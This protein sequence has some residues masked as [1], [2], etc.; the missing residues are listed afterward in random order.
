[1]DTPSS[2]DEQLRQLTERLEKLERLVQS[3]IQRIFAIEKRLASEAPPVQTTSTYSSAEVLRGPARAPSAQAHPGAEF[4]VAPPASPPKQPDLAQ[5]RSDILP[6]AVPPQSTTPTG[7][8]LESLIGGNWLNKI[9]VVAI[10]LGMAY[11]LKYAIDNQWIGEMGRV[12]LGVI[13]GLGFLLWGEALQKRLYRGYGL[14]ISAGGITILYF[15]IFAAFNFYS[16]I[17]QLPALFLM[18]LITTTAVL[19]ALRHDAK[20]IALIGILGGFLTPVM[21]STG[22][23]NQSGLFSYVAL[24]DLGILALAYFK[25]WRELNLLA[26][27]FTQ[28]TF[29]GWSLSFYTSAKLW[30]TELFLTLFFLIFAVMSFLYNIVYQRKT[31]FRDLS[32]ILLN[33]AAYFLWTYGL[34]QEKYFDYLG[35]YAILMAVVYVGL[36]SFAYQRARQ[37]AYLVLVFLGMGLTSLT[38]AIPIQLKQN[39]IT[40]AWAVESVVLSWVGFLAPDRK[41]R[42]ASLLIAFLVA[43]RLLFY[44]SQFFPLVNSDFTF[45]FNQRSFTFAISIL[46]IFAIAYLCARHREKLEGLESGL[47]AGL[48]MAANFLLIFFL[49]TEM[50]HYFEIKYYREKIYELQRAINNQKQLSISALWAIYS[51]GLVT[52]GILRRYQPIRLLAIILFGLTIFKV[53]FVDLSELDK[54]YRIV[55]FVGLGIILLGVSFMYQK[56]RN[57]INEFVLK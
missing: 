4:Q 12:T 35:L 25:D 22:K 55:S 26:F 34:L 10:V 50:A 18:V 38:L 56:Y 43:I 49:T 11:F 48:I 7:E 28:L 40:I 15:S 17:T 9:G 27:I 31:S 1:M 24:L 36:G 8:S 23:D 5:T 45:L 16:L 21:L 39:W 14:T 20:I 57:Q 32:L 47:V 3:Q 44:D 53:F 13:T 52:I 6:S 33:G 37:D 30:L 29:L 41:T 54:I 42:L 51:I 46:A 19:M 2:L